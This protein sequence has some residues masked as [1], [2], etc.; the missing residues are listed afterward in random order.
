M[1]GGR[2]SKQGRVGLQQPTQGGRGGGETENKDRGGIRS[3][4]DGEE[5][6][7]KKNLILILDAKE[8]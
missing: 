8:R 3:L 1:G 6:Q 4:H 5:G 2:D 7:K